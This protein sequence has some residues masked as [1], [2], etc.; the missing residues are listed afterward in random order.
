MKKRVVFIASVLSLLIVCTPLFAAD[1]DAGNGRMLGLGME[2]GFPWGGL[3]SARYWFDSKFGVEGIV[4]AWG[5]L[6]DVTGTFTGRVLY[7]LSDAEAVG[8]YI[9]TGA[10]IPFSPYGENELIFSSAG[11]IEFSFPFA[12]NLA[13]NLEFGGALS[14]TG[15]FMMALGTGI[16]FY[17]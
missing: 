11:G 1:S 2:V 4:F 12:P 16:H 7:K 17:F 3:V 10:T 13:L 14:I 15:T 9:A 5:N 6:A 8:F